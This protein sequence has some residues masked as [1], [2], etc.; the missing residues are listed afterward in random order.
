MGLTQEELIATI[1]EEKPEALKP[2]LCALMERFGAKE[3][4][5]AWALMQDSAQ[6]ADTMETMR[7]LSLGEFLTEVGEPPPM[8]VEQ[9]LP[10][11]S[12]ILLSG[13]P[14]HGKSLLTLDIME[15]IC[16]NRPVFGEYPVNRHGPVV[17]FGMED[18]RYEIANRFLRRGAKPGD[19]SALYICADRFHIG[20]PQS[21]SELKSRVQELTPSLITIDTAR[22]ALGIK[23]WSNPAEV[24]E[25]VRPVRDFAREVCTV[26]LVAHNRKMEGDNGDEIAGSNAFTSSVDGWISIHRKES[27]ANHNLRLYLR[28]EGRGGLR[29]E[30]V[31]EMNTD[32]LRF[33]RLTPEQAAEARRSAQARDQET[34]RQQQ[35]R[36]VLLWMLRND[37]K[38]TAPDVERELEI[39]V[40]AAQELLKFMAEPPCLWIEDSGERT[41]KTKSAIVYTLTQI[42][43][44]EA[45]KHAES[46][47]GTDALSRFAL[48]DPDLWDEGEL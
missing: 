12:L 14:K 17:Y 35:A 29:G 25:K 44:H 18:G 5:T 6:T 19:E 3:V 30:D 34:K 23:D 41:G 38:G 1:K 39:S 21:M 4:S 27:L 7:L 48:D 37:G 8:L 11:K 22:E 9:L 31:V 36:T 42:G 26:L 46:L 16:R 43:K 10:E 24:T 32:T 15:A 28:K 20:S 47:E 33:T 40:R 13:K 2:L 45:R